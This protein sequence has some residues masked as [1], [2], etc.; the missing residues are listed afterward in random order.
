MIV[1]KFKGIV[2]KGKVE[3]DEIAKYKQHLCLLENK[4]VS[5]VVKPWEKQRSNQENRYY[6]GVVVKLISDHTGYTPDETHEAIKFKFLRVPSDDI[7]LDGFDTV[8]STTELTTVEFEL[9]MVEIREWAGCDLGVY[10]PEPN[11]V[12]WEI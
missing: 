9:L 3:L 11:E 10:I 5:L 1:P 2:K 6:W 7:D 8:K 12:E 4:D